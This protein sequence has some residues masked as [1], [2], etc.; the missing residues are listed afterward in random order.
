MG[1]ATAVSRHPSAP[2]V[3][4]AVRVALEMLGP[5]NEHAGQA[6]EGQSEEKS[7][8]ACDMQA[9]TAYL[10]ELGVLRRVQGGPEEGE[11]Q[12]EWAF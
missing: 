10:V 6:G 7:G 8:V 5:A 4:Q 2:E 1:T 11:T 3:G 9:A 12:L